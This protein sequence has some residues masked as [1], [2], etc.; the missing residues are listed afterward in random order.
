MYLHGEYT[1]R[2]NQGGDECKFGKEYS[3]ESNL[4]N[5]LSLRNSLKEED[6]SNRLLEKTYTNM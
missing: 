6:T 5:I 4:K 1:Y 3:P 2:K